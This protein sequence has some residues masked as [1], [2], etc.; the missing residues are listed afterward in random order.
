MA[1]EL[2]KAKLSMCGTSYSCEVDKEA[3]AK[4]S[5]LKAATGMMLVYVRKVPRT[6]NQL[7]L[8]LQ[9]CSTCPDY[10][11]RVVHLTN[12]KIGDLRKL[13]T[14][15]SLHTGVFLEKVEDEK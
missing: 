14:A 6:S 4:K 12:K 13:I 1:I 3:F 9:C 11:N 10:R 15:R 2:V 7:T 8:S 5:K